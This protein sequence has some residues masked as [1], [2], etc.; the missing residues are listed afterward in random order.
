MREL[1]VASDQSEYGVHLRADPDSNRLGKRLKGDFKRVSD[2]VKKL[3]DVQLKEF[4]KIGEID[5]LGHTLTAEDV[6]VR[7]SK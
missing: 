7:T 6:K 2:E 1:K 5:I 3:T 4:E